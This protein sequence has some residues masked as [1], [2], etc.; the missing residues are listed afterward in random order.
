[1]SSVIIELQSEALDKTVKVS[2][3]LRK[4]LVVARKL[5]IG[6]FQEWI[7]KELNGYDDDAPDYRVAKGKV[8]G[9]NPYNGWIPL[10]F[11]DPEEAAVYSERAAGQTIAEIENLLE[12][13]NKSGLH[14]PFPHDIQRQLSKGFGYETEVTL[15]V[16]QESLVRVVDAVRNI[17]LNWTLKLEE[18]GVLG[19]GLQF[20]ET[21]KEAA[22]QSPQNVTN[23]YGP[24]HG[25]QI[26]LGNRKSIQV[27]SSFQLDIPTI[28]EYLEKLNSELPNIELD[29]DKKVEIE[30]EIA[31]IHAQAGS[32]NPKRGIVKESLQSIRNVLEGASGS[33]AGQLLIEVGKLIVG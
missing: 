18:D 7:E 1:M 31:T 10:I 22:A 17:I 15:S 29:S 25:S 14:M 8:I 19:E 4:A 2:D 28:A 16:G 3:L 23:F 11:E 21:E 32:P 5:K 13:G 9:W 12:K 24:I 20:S 33:A 27:S 6:E 30:S 26:A